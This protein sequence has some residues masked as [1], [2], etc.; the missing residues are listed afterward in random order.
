MGCIQ[1]NEIIDAIVRKQICVK[2]N[3]LDNGE[4]LIESMEVV[5]SLW[6]SKSATG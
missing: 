5:I 4:G 2:Y 1:S 6:V 3:A